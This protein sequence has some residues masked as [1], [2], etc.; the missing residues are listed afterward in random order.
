[1]L[2]PLVIIHLNHL[3]PYKTIQRYPGY[4]HGYGNP[5]GRVAQVMATGPHVHVAAHL[6]GMWR[7]H[8]QAVAW[9]AKPK[10]KFLGGEE[11]TAF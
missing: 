2:L 3:F 4:P 11:N 5:G 1:M 8:T 6:I 9:A 7:V 10:K